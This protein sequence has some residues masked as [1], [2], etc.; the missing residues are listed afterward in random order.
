MRGL[1]SA[2]EQKGFK[3]NKNDAY[4]VQRDSYQLGD[5]KLDYMDRTFG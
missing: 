5:K 2:G 4:L 1:E 3:I